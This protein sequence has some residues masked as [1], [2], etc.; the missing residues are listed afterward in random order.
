MSGRRGATR[1]CVCL[2]LPLVLGG[3]LRALAAEA[4]YRGYQY[5]FYDRAVPAPNAYLPA[6]LLTGVEV[7]R[8]GFVGAEDMFITGDELYI[9]D[10]RN[11]RIIATTVDFEEFTTITAE[12]AGG[13]NILKN[14]TGFYFSSG[15]I[16]VANP[17]LGK[18]YIL[19]GDGRVLE[20]IGAPDSILYDASLQFKPS[21][22]LIDSH[23]ITYII[24]RGCTKGA[25]TFDGDLNFIG[26]FG[27]SRIPVTASVLAN[28]FWKF[29]L[30]DEQIAAMSQNIPIEFE[31]F[32]VDAYNF[33]F[34]ATANIETGLNQI[35]KFNPQSANILEDASYADPETARV[36]NQNARTQFSDVKALDNGMFAAVDRASGKGYLYNVDGE[37]LSVFGGIGTA[38][39]LSIKPVAIE[40]HGTDVFVLDGDLNRI[41][42]YSL[43]E[44]GGYL[45]SAAQLYNDGDY[46]SSLGDWE[47]VLAMNAGSRIAYIGAGKAYLGMSQAKKAM[48]LFKL[49]DSRSN[50][51]DAFDF[52]RR[53]VMRGNIYFILAAILA[54]TVYALWPKKTKQLAYDMTGAFLAMPLPRRVL[55][56]V[57]HPNDSYAPLAK[58][59]KRTWAIPAAVL[60]AWFMLASLGWQFTGFAFNAHNLQNFRVTEI[61]FS[62]VVIYALFCASNWLFAAMLHGSGKLMDI[63]IVSSVALIPYLASLLINLILSNVLL[64][65]EGGA[66]LIVTVIAVIWSAVLMLSGMMNLHE[67]SFFAAIGLILLTLFGI[68]VIAFLALLL[69]S[70]G[71]QIY[72]FFMSV[73][74]ELIVIITNG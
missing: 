54:V 68:L 2:L 3:A 55:H 19:D 45:V 22:I 50:Y 8:D 34:T 21:K 65:G 72:G 59:S 39:G 62:T 42:V 64:R 63:L 31:N 12:S 16:Y 13:A 56:T 1:A 28:Y 25:L 24:S 49:A 30:N 73:W 6:R 5:D 74:E 18:A 46:I 4:P 70:L 44:Y 61:L 20:E 47:N 36:F 35:Q 33:I 53:D 48:E 27:S 11:G 52:Y 17:D 38:E 40:A 9:L 26:Y 14:A 71:Q 51:S 41:T 60:L 58:K 7:D 43:S 69:W 57:F 10:G 15:R 67:L 32:D 66:M 37:I 29:F 23:G